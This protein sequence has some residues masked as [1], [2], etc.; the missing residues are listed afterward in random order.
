[1]N[2]VK[3][4]FGVLLL[5]VAVWM[6]QRVLPGA[7]TLVLWSLLVFLT[8]VFLG[9]LEPLPASAGPARRLAKGLGVLACLYGAL[10]LIG[11][12]LGGEDPLRPIP[13]KIRS[14]QPA[15]SASGAR[16]KR[17]PLSADRNGRGARVA[18]SPKRAAARHR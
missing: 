5:G 16:Q 3:A 8:G 18:R 1:M 11:A 17:P 14:R 13:R 6:M 7:V 12:T 2:A 9:A 15:R 4:A 10:L